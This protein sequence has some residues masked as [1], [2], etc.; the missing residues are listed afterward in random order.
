MYQ[1]DP[2]VYLEKELEAY[3]IIPTHGAPPFTG[4]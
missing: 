1:G 3:K 2:L 4:Q